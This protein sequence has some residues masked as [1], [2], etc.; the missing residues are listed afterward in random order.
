MPS[1]GAAVLCSQCARQ[2]GN[3]HD[4]ITQTCPLMSDI[5]THMHDTNLHLEIEF[6]VIAFYVDGDDMV[7]I[8]ALA[9][10]KP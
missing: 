9:I 5:C 6:E 7:V 10:A 8:A 4:V 3:R 1:Y 2:M